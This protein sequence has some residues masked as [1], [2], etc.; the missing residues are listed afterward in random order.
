MG[1]FRMRGLLAACAGTALFLVGC[2][3]SGGS[4]T[5]PTH[6]MAADA[7]QCDKCQVTWVKVPITPGG[8]KDYRVIGYSARKQDACPDCRNALPNFFSG[9]KL[10]HECKACGGNMTICEKSHG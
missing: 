2:Q 5:Q 9:G 4:G 1:S 10:R 7:V 8:G 3:S 6:E